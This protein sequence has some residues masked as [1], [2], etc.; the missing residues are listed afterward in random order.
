MSVNIFNAI[1]FFH[2]YHFYCYSERY[3]SFKFKPFVRI[4]KKSTTSKLIVCDK[5]KQ[6][7]LRYSKNVLIS[8]I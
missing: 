3:I 4:E 8:I 6:L 2:I 1:Y 7:S 5:K